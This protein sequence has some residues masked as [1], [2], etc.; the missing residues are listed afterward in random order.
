MGIE[1]VDAVPER[2]IPD[3]IEILVESKQ[4]LLDRFVLQHFLLVMALA[5]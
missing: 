1:L 2:E 5:R 4:E 3:E